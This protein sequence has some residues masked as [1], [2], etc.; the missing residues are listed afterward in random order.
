[1]RAAELVCSLL[2][3]AVSL[4]G[5]WY[6]TIP[7]LVK[8]WQERR[9]LWRFHAAHPTIEAYVDHCRRRD[10]CRHCGEGREEGGEAE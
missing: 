2:L 1:M 10:V 3:M 6:V 5:I 4:V 9:R 7:A 8:E